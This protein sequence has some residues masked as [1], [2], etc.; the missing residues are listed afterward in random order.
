MISILRRDSRPLSLRHAAD[1]LQALAH[2]V[3]LQ[4]LSVLR[5]APATVTPIVAELGL[6]QPIVSRHLAVL[7]DAGV[8]LSRAEGRERV[9]EL[10]GDRAEPLLGVLFDEP[11][12]KKRVTG[13]RS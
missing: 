2:P 6:E 5:R 8:V 7:R 4:I 11:Q 12:P 13:A 10:T 1:L 9:Y 3:R